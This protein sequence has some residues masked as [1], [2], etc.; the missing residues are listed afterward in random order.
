MYDGK[1]R[2]RPLFILKAGLHF[3]CISLFL[4]HI[5]FLYVCC[6]FQALFFV[7]IIDILCVF[8]SL[9][10]PETKERV[11]ELFPPALS[12]PPSPLIINNVIRMPYYYYL[13]AVFETSSWIF[14]L[15]RT[16]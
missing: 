15:M 16:F 14:C 7:I 13:V 11:S 1:S 2:T 6:V 8:C 4:A 3:K 12:L 10:L 5:C 9:S